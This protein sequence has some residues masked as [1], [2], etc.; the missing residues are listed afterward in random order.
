MSQRGWWRHNRH[1]IFTLSLKNTK[2]SIAESII[3][4]E[5]TYH[6]LCPSLASICGKEDVPRG[7]SWIQE[8]WGVSI[9]LRIE[10]VSVVNLIHV[11]IDGA[12]QATSSHSRYWQDSAISTLS[13]FAKS[14]QRAMLPYQYIAW[15]GAVRPFEM[16]GLLNF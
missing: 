16:I 4:P 7:V 14:G 3:Y 1:P 11:H 12:S 5:A 10:R 15:G 13:F 6:C 8:D 2:I 9:V